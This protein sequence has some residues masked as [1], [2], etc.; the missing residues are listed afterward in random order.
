MYLDLTCCKMQQK[1]PTQ[2]TGLGNMGCLKV[3]MIP[4]YLNIFGLIWYH[5]DH[6]EVPYSLNQYHDWDFFAPYS[7][8]TLVFLPKNTSFMDVL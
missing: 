5:S 4:K 2:K 8:T 6:S 1:S 7:K 3:T